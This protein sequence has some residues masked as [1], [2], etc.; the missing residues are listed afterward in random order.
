MPHSPPSPASPLPR[1]LIVVAS[2]AICWH[3]GAI[4][5]RVL[6]APSGP[7]A[8]PDGAGMFT[9]PQFA[10]KLDTT[11]GGDYLRLIKMTS[12]YHFP[13][14]QTGMPACY[15]E[16]KNVGT[17]GPDLTKR[18]SA[19]ITERVGR[20][21]GVQGARLYIEFYEAKGH[22]WGFGGDTFG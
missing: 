13:S 3:L 20:A 5:V 4:C 2:V 12:N 14:H 6:A 19:A 18:L 1:W 17:L 21:T 8:T 16:V 7:M 15:V 10:Y 22:H 9:P 11:L